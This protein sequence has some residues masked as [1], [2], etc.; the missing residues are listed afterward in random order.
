MKLKTCYF[1]QAFNVYIETGTDSSSRDWVM[2]EEKKIPVQ[3]GVLRLTKYHYNDLEFYTFGYWCN[4]P[5]ERPRHGGEWSSNPDSIRQHFGIEL[6]NVGLDSISVAM[7]YEQLFK[8]FNP[9]V[10]QED[11]ENNIV[12]GLQ[13]NV[14]IPEYNVWYDENGKKIEMSKNL[15]DKV[16]YY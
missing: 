2:V 9:D 8:L 5:K 7:T 12:L 16:K 1:N 4:N 3:N 15:Y 13:S 11:K 10:Y 6:L 14:I